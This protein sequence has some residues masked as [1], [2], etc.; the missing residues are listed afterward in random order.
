MAF[1]HGSIDTL[2]LFAAAALAVVLGLPLLILW[3]LPWFSRSAKWRI[4]AAMVGALAGA[5]SAVATSDGAVPEMAVAVAPAL[6]GILVGAWI[7]MRRA[8][9]GLLLLLLVA[10]CG[11]GSSDGVRGLSIFDARQGTTRRYTVQFE[12]PRGFFR[13]VG[14]AVLLDA[15]GRSHGLH[16]MNVSSTGNE[17]TKISVTF[18]IPPD[19]Q[20]VTVRFPG[21]DFDIRQ[22]RLTR[23]SM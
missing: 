9:T 6:T 3:L 13:T 20:P 7:A 4:S 8:R 1:L 11:W 10:G 21:A 5:W 23:R 12:P 16:A 15:D 22:S 17:V 2:I 19:A 18:D 14:N